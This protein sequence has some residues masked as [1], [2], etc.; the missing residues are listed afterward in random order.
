MTTGLENKIVQ[1]ADDTTLLAVVRSPEMRSQVAMSL[2]RDLERI[3]QWCSRWGMRLNS[4]KTKTLLISR[5]RTNE[6]PHPPL[7][8][9]NTLLAESEFLTILGVTYDSPDF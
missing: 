3:S 5:S 9:G 1:Y 4:S 2:N 6:P 7:L 8:V